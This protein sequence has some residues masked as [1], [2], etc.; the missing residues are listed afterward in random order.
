MR[1]DSTFVIDKDFMEVTI[2]QI[3]FLKIDEK[4]IYEH[5]LVNMVFTFSKSDIVV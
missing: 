3:L 1:I 2:G 5:E 4:L